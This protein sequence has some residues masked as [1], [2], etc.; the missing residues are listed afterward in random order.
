MKYLQIREC[1][2]LSATKV[3][4]SANILL[5][6]VEIIDHMEKDIYEPTVIVR[7]RR[8]QKEPTQQVSLY[9]L[10]LSC[11]H[12]I[13]YLNYKIFE[14]N[15]HTCNRIVSLKGYEIEMS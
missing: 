6:D 1:S 12:C 2:G 15:V 5:K 13:L 14:V 4:K 8:M 7:R 11:I 3:M 9:I 10:L